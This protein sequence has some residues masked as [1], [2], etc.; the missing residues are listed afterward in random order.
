MSDWKQDLADIF[1]KQEEQTQKQEQIQS[2][3][4]DEVKTFIEFTVQPAFTNLKIELQKHG[5]TVDLS[6]S[7]SEPSITIKN[8]N[9]EELKFAI[10]FH[11]NRPYPITWTREGRKTYKGEGSFQSSVQKHTVADISEDEIIQ[12]VLEEYKRKLEYLSRK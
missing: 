7:G 2:Q 10:G 4:Q 5:R 12:H 3:Q 1:K 11:G 6:L 8:E 9:T